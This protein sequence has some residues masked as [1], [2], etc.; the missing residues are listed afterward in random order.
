DTIAAA[1]GKAAT[2]VVAWASQTGFAHDIAR[3]TAA[4]LAEAGVAHT[5]LPLQRLDAGVLAGTRRLLVIASTTGEGD[6]PDHALAFLSSDM[7]QR[8]DLSHLS[9]A[10]LALGDREYAHYCGFGHQLEQWLHACGARP[11]FDLTEVDNGE[12]AALRHWQHHVAQLYGATTQPN[13][14]APRYE[15]WALQARTLANPG[16]DGHEA[17]LVSLQP[18]A[19]ARVEWQA[20]DIVEI[21][22]RN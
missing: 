20:G 10:V 18:P 1:G 8:P 5:L 12:P 22:P 21:G 2:T 15:P 6:P 7:N 11:L 19:G 16:S 3:R 14:E 13:W 9:C 17:F 4:L